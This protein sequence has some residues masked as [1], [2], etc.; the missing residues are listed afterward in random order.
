MVDVTDAMEEVKAEE[1]EESPRT[2]AARVLLGIPIVP[3]VPQAPTAVFRRRKGKGIESPFTAP[4][5]PQLPS[6]AEANPLMAMADAAIGGINSPPGKQRGPR[7]PYKPRKPKVN[8]PPA[9]APAPAQGD[10]QT[11]PELVARTIQ[12]PVPPQMAGPSGC[13]AQ[14]ATSQ[15][16]FT[17]PPW[18]PPVQPPVAAAVVAGQPAAA[19]QQPGQYTHFA[20]S[21]A[22]APGGLTPP[23][24]VL[25][26]GM[27]PPAAPPTMASSSLMGRFA[28]SLAPACG[29]PGPFSS[30]PRHL[31]NLGGA[32]GGPPIGAT[33]QAQAVR[34]GV[35]A[36]LVPPP[37]AGVSTNT[38]PQPP[39]IVGGPSSAAAGGGPPIFGMGPSAA[40]AMAPAGAGGPHQQQ[41]GQPFGVG[42]SS[43]SSAF[44][45]SFSTM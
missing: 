20:P 31:T 13:N 18:Q 35:A 14:P 10:H 21:L 7:G 28:P 27:A 37:I 17:F 4:P 15:P 39:P 42:K 3:I 9:I 30:M 12:P 22:A 11:T 36:P 23:P 8:L 5:Q 19:Q 34:P 25:T 2:A 41:P 32:L 26:A 44:L 16:P 1:L 43:L 29:Q 6:P 33:V 24:T 38:L 45:P 40:P